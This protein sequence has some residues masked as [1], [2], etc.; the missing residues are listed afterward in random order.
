[1][2][3]IKSIELIVKVDEHGTE[4]TYGSEIPDTRG[5]LPDVHEV[6]TI[7]IDGLTMELVEQ[8][9]QMLDLTYGG[10]PDEHGD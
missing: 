9:G 6:S 5:Y 3:K 8:V 4:K 7:T 1:M 2:V 10:K